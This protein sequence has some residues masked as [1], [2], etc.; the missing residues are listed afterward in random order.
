M[1]RR[2]NGVIVEQYLNDPEVIEDEDYNTTVFLD[3]ICSKG[4]TFI[5]AAK[6]IKNKTRH[7]ASFIRRVHGV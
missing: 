3:D 2:E 1:K 5:G 4:T 7:E 6:I